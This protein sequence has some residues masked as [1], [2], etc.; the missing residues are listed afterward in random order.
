[1]SE[2]EGSKKRKSEMVIT[3]DDYFRYN[4]YA[5]HNVY[6]NFAKRKKVIL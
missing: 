6:T 1:M 5:L 3:M 2:G 4:F